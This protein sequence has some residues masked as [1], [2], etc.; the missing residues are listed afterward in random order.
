M[1]RVLECISC[2][3]FLISAPSRTGAALYSRRTGG[4]KCPAFADSR[5]ELS[6]NRDL[7]ASNAGGRVR[8]L[9][10]PRA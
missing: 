9:G 3:S 2:R 7:L 10:Y 6:L 8:G 5:G 4:G 1:L